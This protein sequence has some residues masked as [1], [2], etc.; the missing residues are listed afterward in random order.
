MKASVKIILLFSIIFYGCGKGGPK[1]GAELKGTDAIEYLAGSDSKTWKLESG[2]DYYEYLKFDAKGTVIFQTGG[3]IKY[4]VDAD[5][6]T[7]KDFQ[8]FVYRILEVDEN[9]FSMIL[10]THDTL[11]YALTN[12]KV[13]LGKTIGKSI[14]AKWLKGKFGTAWKFVDGEK[15]YSFMNDGTI[16]DANTL[17]KV[18]DWSIVGDT[19][20]FGPTKLT[21][22]RL[23]PVFFDYDVYGMTVKLNYVGESA[24]DGSVAKK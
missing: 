10:P 20:K 8:D 16:K 24:A 18:D 1:K 17:V 9:K 15:T 19:L 3:S 22:F 4:N 2:H 12:D 23:S 11:H 21:I 6:L 14:D 5:L 7:M 13:E